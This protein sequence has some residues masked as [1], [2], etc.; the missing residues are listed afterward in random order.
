[1]DLKE[2]IVKDI[3]INSFT[4]HGLKLALKSLD[5]NSYEYYCINDILTRF[6]IATTKYSKEL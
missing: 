3:E 6:S 1:M 5:K 4:I 2:F